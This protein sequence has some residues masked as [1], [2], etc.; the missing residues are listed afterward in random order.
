[1]PGDEFGIHAQRL[2]WYREDIAGQRQPVPDGDSRTSN[3]SYAG[4]GRRLWYRYGNW[5]ACGGFMDEGESRYVF[6]LTS[7]IPHILQG[8]IHSSEFPIAPAAPSDSSVHYY[9]VLNA[10]G[11]TIITNGEGTEMKTKF[12][13][14]YNQRANDRD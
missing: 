6:H 3:N 2:T 5:R 14:Y 13:I 11:R 1:M 7:Y 12:N 4:D 9:Q 10:G 8:K